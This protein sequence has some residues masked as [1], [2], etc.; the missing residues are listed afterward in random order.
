[1][2]L[3]ARVVAVSVV[4]LVTLAGCATVQPDARFA[5]VRRVVEERLGQE[6]A[7]NRE[8]APDPAIRARIDALLAPPLTAGAA[9]QIALLNSTSLQAVFED[10]GVAQADLV[11]AG[12][13]RNPDIAGFF[14]V[15]D[16]PPAGLNWNVGVDFW[17]LDIFLV[18]LRKRLSGAALDAAE[19][20]VSSA[21]I[22]TAGQTRATYY[23]AW[24]DERA[25]NVQRDVTELAALAAEFADRQRVAGHVDDLRAATERAT[26]QQAALVLVQAEHAARISRERLRRALGL[27]ASDVAW[28]IAADQSLPAGDDP[29]AEELVRVALAQRLDLAAEKK[30]TERLEYA[31]ELTRKWWLAPVRLGV[32]TEKGSGGQVQTGPHFQFEVPIFDQR[33]AEIAR[34]EALIRQARQRVAD[35]E[36]RI[37]MELRTALDRMRTARQIARYYAED[38]VPLRARLTAMTEQRYQSMFL[39]VFEMLAAK[40][41]ETTARIAAARALHDFWTA[42][43][44]VERVIA[45]RLPQGVTR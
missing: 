40:S 5:D 17:P 25:V 11:Q 3:V 39:G 1:M 7:W 42:R 29:S 38:I 26:S 22:D 43:A 13:I 23:A 9:V 41:E 27:G 16:R 15:P 2:R 4:A 35:L 10:L 33:Q 28:S 32:E 24:S 14:R 19:R 37:R 31:L 34:Q 8:P 18:P 44:E 30:D 20:R 36:G 12:L 21:V 6:L 45:G